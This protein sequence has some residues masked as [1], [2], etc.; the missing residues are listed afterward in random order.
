[1]FVVVLVIQQNLLKKRLLICCLIKS[2]LQALIYLAGSIKAVLKDICK[3]N[4]ALQFQI[5]GIKI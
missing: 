2:K 3:I 1:M 5:S 4:Q